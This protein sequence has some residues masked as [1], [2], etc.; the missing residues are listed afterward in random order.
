[1]PPVTAVAGAEALAVPSVGDR[2]HRDPEPE[3]F[4]ALV[5]RRETSNLSQLLVYP[6]S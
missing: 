2:E 5:E 6:A 1:M 3:R 4:A